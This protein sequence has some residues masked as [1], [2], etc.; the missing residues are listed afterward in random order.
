MKKIKKFIVATVAV[1]VMLLATACG[2]NKTTDNNGTTKNGVNNTTNN[3]ETTGNVVED[4]GRDTVNGVEKVG[5]DVVNGVENIGNDVKNSM[6]G[7]DSYKNVN[8][9][10]A[11]R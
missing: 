7:T 2:T 9:V 3:T 10:T 4:I 5:E 6:D 8:D 11:G 1:S